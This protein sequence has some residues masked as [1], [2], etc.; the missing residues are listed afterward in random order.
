MV[1]GRKLPKTSPPDVA[2]KPSLRREA[3]VVA[4]CCYYGCLALFNLVPVPT[5]CFNPPV[6]ILSGCLIEASVLFVYTYLAENK[7]DFAMT[8]LLSHE[9]PQNRHCDAR[10]ERKQS[11]GSGRGSGYCNTKYY[12]NLNLLS[13]PPPADYM[14]LMS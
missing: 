10:H 8:T 14:R 5:D 9:Q 6:V 7:A 12:F 4:I 11:D 3:R 1:S 2:T 13:S